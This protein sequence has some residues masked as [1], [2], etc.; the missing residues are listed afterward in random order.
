MNLNREADPVAA[1]SDAVA[2]AADVRKVVDTEA[3]KAATGVAVEDHE[4]TINVVGR[5]AV[6][7]MVSR[8]DSSSVRDTNSATGKI[9]NRRCR[10]FRWARPL[11]KSRWR[12]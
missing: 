9:A 4:V 11:D 12:R 1:A 7:R 5:R 10:R 2:P 6:A 8:R 3:D